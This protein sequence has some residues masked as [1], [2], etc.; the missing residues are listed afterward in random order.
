MELNFLRCSRCGSTFVLDK[1]TRRKN[2]YKCATC[3]RELA[4]KRRNNIKPTTTELQN[5]EQ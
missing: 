5:Q 1:R 2:I 4:V 3:G